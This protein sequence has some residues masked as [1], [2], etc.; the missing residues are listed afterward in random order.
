[1]L[2]GKKQIIYL[3]VGLA[4]IVATFLVVRQVFLKPVPPSVTPKLV[5][6]ENQ[7][8]EATVTISSK[9]FLPQTVKI[10]KGSLVTWL[11]QDTKPHQI[12]S[13]PH[14][15]DSLYP[16]LDTEDVLSLDGAVTITFDTVGTF[17]Y[18]D[19]MNP[20]KFKGTVIVE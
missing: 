10:T 1:M 8:P 17:T 18:H 15:S 12:K 4:L 13:D 16:F 3:L 5:K 20:L 14:P 6:I 19:E 7:I 9:G 2:L 11:N